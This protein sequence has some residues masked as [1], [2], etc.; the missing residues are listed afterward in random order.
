MPRMIRVSPPED[1]REFPGPQASSSVTR[2]PRSRRCSAVQPPK[3]PAPMTAMWGFD[4]MMSLHNSFNDNSFN[5]LLSF[6]AQRE[7][8]FMLARAETWIPRSARNDR[9]LRDDRLGPIQNLNFC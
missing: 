9:A 6:R 8:W 5:G 3:A 2:A 1:A 7:S 4:F